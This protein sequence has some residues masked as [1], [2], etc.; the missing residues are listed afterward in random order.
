MWKS[1]I[2]MMRLDWISIWFQNIRS[3]HWM[4]K[5]V[6]VFLLQLDGFDTRKSPASH[7]ANKQNGLEKGGKNAKSFQIGICIPTIS[8]IIIKLSP[9]EWKMKKIYSKLRCFFRLKLWLPPVFICFIYRTYLGYHKNPSSCVP[10]SR[11]HI[12]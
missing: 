7:H 6:F 12:V 5:I 1:S 4:S 11:I 8:W 2:F 9:F 10:I 3:S